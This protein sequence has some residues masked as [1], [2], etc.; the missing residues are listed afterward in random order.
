M[1][2]KGHVQFLGQCL[3]I[4]K[5]VIS[6][7]LADSLPFTTIYNLA[8]NHTYSDVKCASILY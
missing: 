7:P 1:P 5:K 2:I 6:S 4:Q 8:G 3:F